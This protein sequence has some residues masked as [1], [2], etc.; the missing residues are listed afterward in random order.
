MADTL[1]AVIASLI[2]CRTSKL[3][4]NGPSSP[5]LVTITD[6]KTF[7]NPYHVIDI[8]L[9]PSTPFPLETLSYIPTGAEIE[10][11]GGAK[12]FVES[13]IA[14]AERTAAW[15]E[16]A[17]PEVK[18]SDARSRRGAPPR[19]RPG[20]RRLKLHTPRRST[21]PGSAGPSPPT[22]YEIP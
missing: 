15:R 22:P 14:A 21:Y 8:G 9:P 12:G 5:V 7:F 10:R 18:N 2:V 1:H 19:P 13:L 16:Y 17:A 20:R 6:T 4:W 11:A 3:S